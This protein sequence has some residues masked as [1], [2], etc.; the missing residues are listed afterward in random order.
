MA[1]RTFKVGRITAHV[2]A[3]GTGTLAIKGSA[4]VCA[5][6]ALSWIRTGTGFASIVA[7]NGRWNGGTRNHQPDSTDHQNSVHL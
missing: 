5:G 2:L 6:N 7:G 3:V 4:F 1:V